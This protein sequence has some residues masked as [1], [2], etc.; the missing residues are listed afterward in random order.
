MGRVSLLCR[1]DE[2]TS[3]FIAPIIYRTSFAEEPRR[4]RHSVTGVEELREAEERITINEFAYLPQPLV[5]YKIIELDAGE[6]Q[7]R[8]CLKYVLSGDFLIKSK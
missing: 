6:S 4:L 5:R 7:G 2:A 8:P 1:I 3:L